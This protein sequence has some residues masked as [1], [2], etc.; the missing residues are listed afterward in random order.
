VISILLMPPEF[1]TLLKHL[2]GFLASASS[3]PGNIDIVSEKPHKPQTTSFL[4]TGPSILINFSAV[5]QHP[6]V[7]CQVIYL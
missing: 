5:K 4:T 6:T 2:N 1:F 3:T 7:K